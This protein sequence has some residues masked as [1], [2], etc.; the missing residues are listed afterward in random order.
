MYIANVTSIASLYTKF[1]PSGPIKTIVKK[2][3][4]KEQNWYMMYLG[5]FTFRQKIPRIS[6]VLSR[7]IATP[8]IAFRSRRSHLF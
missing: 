3:P 5:F 6:N 1:N 4:R 7:H 8:T 2:E